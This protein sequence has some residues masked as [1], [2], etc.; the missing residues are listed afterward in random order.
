MHNKDKETLGISIKGPA[1]PH[2]ELEKCQSDQ[3]VGNR[4]VKLG[5]VRSSQPA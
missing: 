4:H 3:G 1:S 5:T 2:Y